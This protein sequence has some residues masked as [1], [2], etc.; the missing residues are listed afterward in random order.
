LSA[1]FSKR[2]KR[3][4]LS[5]QNNTKIIRNI[6]NLYSRNTAQFVCHGRYFSQQRIKIGWLCNENK[7]PNKQRN[8]ISDLK[9]HLGTSSKQITAKKLT[10]ISLSIVFGIPAT[11]T[12]RRRFS[13]S[14]I[15]RCKYYII[16]P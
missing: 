2:M 6:I 12:W 7:K 14:F 16:I 8:A 13:T 4:I 10:A 3:S 15:K 11:A 1:L 9:F 5:C